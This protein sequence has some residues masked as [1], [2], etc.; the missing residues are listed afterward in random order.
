M[1]ASCVITDFMGDDTALER[2]LFGRE[3][4]DVFVAE[5]PRPDAWIDVASA[6]DAILTRHAPIRAEEIRRLDRCRI[7]ARYGT[8]HD[9]VDVAAAAERGITVTSVPD[10]CVD[11]VADH[12]F[13]LIL[14]AARHVDVLAASVRS[15]GWT[16]RP[17]PRIRRLRGLRL[18]LLGCGRI[19]AAVAA[20]ASAFGLEAAAYDPYAAELPAGIDRVDS[21]DELVERSDIL[22]LHAPL[23]PETERVLDRERLGRLPGG[24]IV[25]NVARGRLLDVEAAVEAVTSGRLRALALDVLDHEPPPADHPIRSMP[26][27]VVTPHVAYYSTESVEEAKRRSVEEILRALAGEAPVHPVTTTL[28]SA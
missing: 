1:P 28:V 21:V 4:V 18:G 17:L 6:A 24:A 13:A 20:R 16:P 15:G 7:I 22:S 26:G 10:Y 23:T 11:E 8:G 19:G 3:G 25:V 5:S 14:G 2:E 27:V 9:N 12:A